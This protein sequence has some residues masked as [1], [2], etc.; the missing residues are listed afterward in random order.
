MDGL[1]GVV[2]NVFVLIA[3]VVLASLLYVLFFVGEN[4]ALAQVCGAVERPVATFYNDYALHPSVYNDNLVDQ[5]LGITNGALRGDLSS[6][7]PSN[8][9]SA[10]YSTGW[11]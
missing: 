2:K 3:G 9:S 5:S 6:A 4:S 8:T 10:D 7:D 1:N 11:R